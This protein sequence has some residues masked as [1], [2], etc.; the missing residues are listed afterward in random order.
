MTEIW[1]KN[2]APFVCYTL[3]FGDAGDD[4][5]GGG[6]MGAN[7]FNTT[8]ELDCE[9]QQHSFNVGG[10]DCGPLAL[11]R[12]KAT[13]TRGVDGRATV[14]QAT[15]VSIGNRCPNTFHLHSHTGRKKG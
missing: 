12:Q 10:G 7:L 8:Q 13:H 11:T 14:Q 1:V 5:V 15:L 9:F 6:E 3:N 2:S 4:N